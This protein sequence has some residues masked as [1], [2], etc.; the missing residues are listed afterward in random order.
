[1]PQIGGAIEGYRELTARISGMPGVTGASPFILS[2][3]MLGAPGAV[4]GVV[5]RGIDPRSEPAVTDL[6]RNMVAGSL[7]DLERD[8]NEE[9]L[10]GVSSARAARNLD[11]P[12]REVP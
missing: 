4:Q 1:V 5:V 2:Q 7:A 9:G 6:A 11:R 12:G 3:A 8:P 10:P